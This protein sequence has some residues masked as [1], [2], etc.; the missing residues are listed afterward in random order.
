MTRVLP[1]K[2][3]HIYAKITKLGIEMFEVFV[4]N[5]IMIVVLNPN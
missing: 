4:Y 3:R 2:K 1:R 5:G